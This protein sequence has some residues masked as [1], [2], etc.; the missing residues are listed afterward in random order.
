MPPKRSRTPATS[1][2]MPRK[3]ANN[4]A[5]YKKPAKPSANKRRWMKAHPGEIPNPFHRN[6]IG[7]T[8]PSNPSTIPATQSRKR[9][10]LNKKKRKWLRDHPGE[11]LDPFHRDKMEFNGFSDDEAV[12]N[13]AVTEKSDDD[14]V[15]KNGLT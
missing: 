12:A 14:A 15:P 13:H 11:T 5:D 3:R 6:K 1:S 10:H 9:T 8:V 2:T 7:S 4:T